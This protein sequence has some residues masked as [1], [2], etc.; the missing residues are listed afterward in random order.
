MNKEDVLAKSKK[1]NIYGDEREREV[2][3]KRDA[4][5]GWG[6]TVLGIIIMIIKIFHGDSASDIISI[7]FCT[8]GLAFTY[9]GMKLQKKW[10]A[11]CGIVL[12]L[13]STYYFYRFCVGI[14]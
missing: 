7:L 1:E 10:T 14:V 12:L 11:I 9:E 3:T 13:F 4:F 6:F 5:A 8:S 2:R